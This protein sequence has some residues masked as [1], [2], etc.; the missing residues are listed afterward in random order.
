MPDNKAKAH[1]G[2]ALRSKEIRDVCMAIEHIR[3]GIAMLD[4]LPA[5]SL[6]AVRDF[7]AFQWGD[8]KGPMGDFARA[9]LVYVEEQV[10]AARERE[11][12]ESSGL[13]LGAIDEAV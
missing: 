12:R 13:P 9:Y 6:E 5:P 8:R 7:V 2:L 3:T 1:M 4:T 10:R 11:R